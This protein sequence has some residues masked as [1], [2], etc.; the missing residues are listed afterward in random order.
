MMLLKIH[1]ERNAENQHV[2]NYQ[3]IMIRIATQNAFRQRELA[4]QDD[5]HGSAKLQA[6]DKRKLLDNWWIPCNIR[7]VVETD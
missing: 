1:F 4:I 3:E 6:D 7:E 2:I 5:L